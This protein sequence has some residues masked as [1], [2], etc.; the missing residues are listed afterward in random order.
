MINPI[1]NVSEIREIANRYVSEASQNSISL[2]KAWV[3][4]YILGDRKK[5]DYMLSLLKPAIVGV[6]KSME[7]RF[8]TDKKPLYRGLLLPPDYKME[9]YDLWKY[10]HVSF[11]EDI[12][13]AEAFSNIS[14]QYGIIFPRN[15]IGHIIKYTPKD[16]DHIWFNYEW[17]KHFDDDFST[18]IKMWNQKELIIGKF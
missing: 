4:L 3:M 7:Q 14:S 18:F 6:A 1:L 13:V 16:T 12:E 10:D 11:T 17:G 9:D 15:Y 5:S 2:Y 8:P